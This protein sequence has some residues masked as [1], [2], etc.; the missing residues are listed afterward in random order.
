METEITFTPSPVGRFFT[1]S[2]RWKL[3][4]SGHKVSL[5]IDGK[6]VGAPSNNA[7]PI[8]VRLG[9]FWASVERADGR[10]GGLSKSDA[11][12]LNHLIKS[13]AEK[14]RVQ[15]AE[16]APTYALAIKHINNWVESIEAALAKAKADRRW[17]TREQQGELLARRPILS[18]S[19]I[20]LNELASNTELRALAKLS[21][22]DTESTLENWRRDWISTW[23]EVNQTHTQ[24]ELEAS[25]PLLSKVESRPLT[26]EQAKAVICFDNRV[27]VVASARSGKTSIM[28]AKAAYAI[29]RGIALPSEIILLAFNAAAAEELAERAER[30]FKRLGMDNISVHAKTF[31]KL[32]LDIIGK[33]TNKKPNVPDWAHKDKP[34]LEKM[35][36][37]VDQL[38]DRDP[39]FRTR[40]DL[41]R[42]VFGRDI[43]HFNNKVDSKAQE[44]SPDGTYTL[45]GKYVRSMEECMIANWLFYN[46]VPYEYEPPYPHDTATA[47]HRQYHPDFFYPTLNL[48][49]EH[50]ALDGNGQPPPHFKKYLSG[51]DWKRALHAQKGTH[52]IE[53]TSH[54][55]RQNT[56]MEHLTKE[57]TKRGVTLDPNPSRP[58]SGLGQ[59]PIDHSELL[60]LMRTFIRHA[61]SNCLSLSDLLGRVQQ[62]PHAAFQHRYLKF[63]E[64]LAPVWEGWDK[65]LKAEQG[66]DFEDMLN[67]AARHVENGAYSPPYRLVMADEFQDASQARARLCKA[68]VK[69]PGRHFFAVGDD[70]QSINRFAGADVSVM[71]RFREFFG[72]DQILKL[73]TTFRCPQKIC[74]TSSQFV[75]K[76]PAQLTKNVSSVTP[77]VG[78]E[79]VAYQVNEPA[80][81]KKAVAK[82]LLNLARQISE[83][84]IPPKAGG[85]IKVYVLGRY[86]K[87]EEYVPKDW[88]SQY[89]DLIEL[90][91]LSMHRSKG[92]EADYVILPAM[93]SQKRNRSFPS[94]RADDPLISIAMPQGDSYHLGEERRLFYVALTR[95]RRSVAMFTVANQVS[96]FLTELEKDEQVKIT[97]LEPPGPSCPLCKTGSII[98]RSSVNGDFLTCSNFPACRYKPPKPQPA[99]RPRFA[100]EHNVRSK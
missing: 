19:N 46:G 21:L 40:W 88:Q 9:L 3:R 72:S 70:W 23:A 28:V 51:V 91:F 97:P 33:A 16:R 38:K 17:F 22:Q 89:G 55:I 49:H 52:L 67:M 43:P 69:A 82:Y 65:A 86:N 68:L 95:A 76:N 98:T 30:S 48:Y 31:H 14:R 94:T 74:D 75:V 64:I 62:L 4:V 39:V 10:L 85:K 24:N 35:A 36:L 100:K 58:I 12:H 56:W 37:I 47:E 66:I 25:A 57:L 54:Q 61:K 60:S 2:P 78:T 27:Q 7:S 1:A 5:E 42:L 77:A 99:R 13:A 83:G 81:L 15:L 63:L 59:A 45:D 87:D 32:G 44:A 26:E 41:F 96:T 34:S 84:T 80:A 71:T 50:F 53:T 79:L 90:S 18:V 92:A 29:N 93:L 20:E 73:E 6:A 11:G 8:S